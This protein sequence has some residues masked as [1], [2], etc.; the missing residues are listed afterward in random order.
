M[1]LD[2]MES[3]LFFEITGQCKVTNVIGGIQEILSSLNYNLSNNVSQLS[4]L[5]LQHHLLPFDECLEI[6]TATID[7]EEHEKFTKKLYSINY[8]KLEENLG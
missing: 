5:K 1:A 4:L 2:I 8:E 3:I 7:Q 6:S